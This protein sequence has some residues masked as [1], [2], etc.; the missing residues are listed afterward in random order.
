MLWTKTRT[1]S[2]RSIL[3]ETNEPFFHSKWP[4]SCWMRGEKSTQSVIRESRFY[5]AFVVRRP[6]S[7]SMFFCLSADRSLLLDSFLYVHRKS[8]RCFLI[9]TRQHPFPIDC[10]NA[11]ADLLFVFQRRAS[12]YQF[13]RNVISLYR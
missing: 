3:T 12:E 13:M 6:I 5:N 8:H 1:K 10:H 7:V 11:C 9:R 4:L 2:L